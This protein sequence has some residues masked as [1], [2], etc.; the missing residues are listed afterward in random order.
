[1]DYLAALRFFRAIPTYE[2]N[3]NGRPTLHPRENE[4]P[5]L[6]ALQGQVLLEKEEAEPRKSHDLDRSRQDS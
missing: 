1:M 2:P 5:F 4:L 3:T 6:L